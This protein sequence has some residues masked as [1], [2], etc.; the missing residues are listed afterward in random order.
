MALDHD[1]QKSVN[2]IAGVGQSGKTTFGNRLLANGDFTT[3][4]IFDPENEAAERFGLAPTRSEFDLVSH[5]F[6]GWV[7][8]DPEELFGSNYETAFEFFCEWVFAKAAQLPGAKILMVDE[9]WKLCPNR[10]IPAELA[11]IVRTG[12]KRGLASV[13]LT[14]T[15]N[16]L[17]GV[18]LNEVTEFV[19]FRLQSEAALALA[20]RRGFN[21]DE[22]ASLANLNFIS[23]TDLGGERR[24][25]PTF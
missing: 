12:R 1:F 2:V 21:R 20:E 15:P 8:F 18:I 9:V 11:N 7:L 24:G 16:E 13:F 22:L 4:F 23:R 25:A 5:L 6:R 17:P 19:A 14:Q 3:R 10:T